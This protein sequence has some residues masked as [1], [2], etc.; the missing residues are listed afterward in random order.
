MYNASL[1]GNQK[2]VEYLLA[3]GANPNLQRKVRVIECNTLS[4][5]I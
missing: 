5:E 1:N 3:A 4:L 2:V